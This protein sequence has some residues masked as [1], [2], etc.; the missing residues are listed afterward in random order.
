MI[1][2]LALLASAPVVTIDGGQVTGVSSK[3]FRRFLGIA[4]AAAPIGDLRGRPPRR[5]TPPPMRQATSFAASCTQ[6]LSP[7][8]FGPW[9]KEFVV[10]GA[11]S[12]DCLFLNVWAPA[13]ARK[14]P[15]L[16]WIHGGGFVS[17]SGSIP[18][19]DGS[20][21]ARRGVVVVTVNYRLGEDGFST[22]SGGLP[23][24]GALDLLA[25]L[26]WV[27]RNAS[28]FGGDPKRVTIAGQSAGAM[29][30][31]G[32]TAMPKARGLFAQA[33]M[34]SGLPPEAG[35]TGART[36]L[37]ISPDLPVS[38]STVWRQGTGIDVPILVGM[39]SDE[40]T[41][42]GSGSSTAASPANCGGAATQL[43]GNG[44]TL[45]SAAT[46]CGR[47]AL[48]EWWEG[49]AKNRRSPV[50]A[51][52]FS[53]VPQGPDAQ[54]WGAFH[55]AE[56]PYVFS[57]LGAPSSRPY[58]ATDMRLSLR[59]IEAWTRFVKGRAPWASLKGREPRL[60]DFSVQPR[61]RSIVPAHINRL[62]GNG[63]QPSPTLF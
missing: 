11:V 1:A 40:T 60:Q 5:F 17:G 34:Q 53:H 18:I 29:L 19:Y 25:A 50:Y 58:T 63:D 61:T 59:M 8:G 30:V 24:L 35:P 38:P 37:R 14:A 23:N 41:A 49:R 45:R 15:I 7:N 46:W 32:L 42:F 33:I 57:T 31:H 47:R 27:N 4:Y 12:N 28:A 36:R 48:L 62:F 6:G 22:V 44:L 43:K 3:S 13:R 51:Y 56:L 55:S 54:R 10:A 20:A 21:F 16:F 9:T 2:A 52:L 39:T 26:Q